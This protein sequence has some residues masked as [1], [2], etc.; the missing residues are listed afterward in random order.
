M[1]IIFSHLCLFS[2]L[3]KR[4]I[5]MWILISLFFLISATGY[6]SDCSSSC[7]IADAPAPALTEYF[8][9]IQ[10]IQSN[11][12]NALNDAESDITVEKTNTDIDSLSAWKRLLQSLNSLLNFNDHFSSFDYKI[13][14]P[15]TNEVP[16]EVKRDHRMLENIDSKLSSILE[17][18][19]R[20]NIS[21]VSHENIC[22]GVS[23]C[24][25]NDVSIRWALILI[26]K[27]NRE[28]IRLY[29]TSILDKAYLAE[30]RNFILVANDFEKQLQEYYN[31]DTLGLCSKCEWNTWVETSEKIKNISIKN[32]AYKAGIQKWKDA[33]ALMRGWNPAHNTA[34][35]NIV[36]SEYLSSQW[37]SW[38]Q[39]DVI[40]DNLKRYGSWSISAS[41]PALNSSN[42]ARASIDNTIDS[43]SQTLSEQFE[44]K[45]RVPIIQLAEVNSELKSSE[46][47]ALSIESL[48]KDQL[49]F[50][51]S[52]DTWSQEL[53]LRILRMHSS[54]V[55]SINELQKNK[56]VSEKLC[57]KQ[58]T[59]M[60][61]CSY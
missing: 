19:S 17:T 54:L 21:W 53:Q 57:D 34:T 61:R 48:Y 38:S 11:I 13:S 58:W 60:W 3:K 49:P 15:I 6:S 36:L 18:M 28:I 26:I 44:W 12:I 41:N 33:W 29:E 5:K 55:R 31:K 8:A 14:L 16:N 43:F 4:G 7:K 1:N 22:D 10:A 51:Q 32:S 9:N 40:L 2:S 45:E 46:D 27:N 35:Q 23:Y 24:D 37:I 56:K 50:A 25:I 52:Q 39:W 42:Y 59:G 30:N 47:L 20:R